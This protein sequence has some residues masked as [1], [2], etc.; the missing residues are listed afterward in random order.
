V[1]SVKLNLF[2]GATEKIDLMLN[3][4]KVLSANSKVLL[5][6]ATTAE[7]YRYSVPLIDEQN[8]LSEFDGF[9]IALGFKSLDELKDYYA[10]QNEDFAYDLLLIDTDD[11]K[12]VAMWPGIVNQFLV[13]SLEKICIHRNAELLDRYFM[14]RDK[15]TLT[16]F[17]MVYYP[18]VDC[19]IDEA[20]VSASLERFPIVWGDEDHSFYFDEADYAVRIDN[21][22]ENRIL[23][24]R[25]SRP[26]KSSLLSICKIISGQE[27]KEM[28]KIFKQAERGR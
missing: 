24:K 22:F 28:K 12:S 15:A 19:S 26:Y 7:K 27:K 4:C 8:K 3:I 10:T 2:I 18:F 13:S 20:F 14:N 25:L 11:L 16:E 21:Q 6:D 9:D 1:T 17:N 23:L 5:V